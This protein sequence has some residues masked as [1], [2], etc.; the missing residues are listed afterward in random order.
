M[1]QGRYLK[2]TSELGSQ[3]EKPKNVYFADLMAEPLEQWAVAVG[4]QLV[5]QV[6]QPNASQRNVW[7]CWIGEDGALY[8]RYSDAAGKFGAR[9]ENLHYDPTSGQLLDP[10]TREHSCGSAAQQ[11]SNLYDGRMN[12]T[13]VPTNAWTDNEGYRWWGDAPDL[14]WPAAVV[15]PRSHTIV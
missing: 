2:P 1:S 15:Q 11:A 3:V 7:E 4:Q 9:F 14:G 6:S 10:M 8:I 5:W 12:A 13:T